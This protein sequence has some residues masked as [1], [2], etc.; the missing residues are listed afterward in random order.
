MNTKSILQHIR[1][2]MSSNGLSAYII[3]S[4]DRHQNEYVPKCWR[5]REFVSGF[6]GSAGDLLVGKDFSG[7]WTDSRYHLQAEQQLKGT[8]IVLFK[9]GLQDVPSMNEYIAQKLSAGDAVGL[10]PNLFSHNA[11]MKLTK[12]LGSKSIKIK[13]ILENPVDTFSN[14]N[15]DIPSNIITPHPD[16]FSGESIIS[17]LA[18]TREIMAKFGSDVLLVNT[19]DSVA[20]VY[21]IRGTDV[22]YNPVAIGYGAIETNTAYLFVAKEK[23]TQALIKH[24]QDTVVIRDYNEFEEYLEKLASTKKTIIA[25]PENVS[26]RTMELIRSNEPTNR[27]TSVLFARNPITDLKAIKNE[28]ELSGIR[29]AHKRDGVALV[30]FF[31]WLEET[32]PQQILTEISAAE[33]LADFRSQGKNYVGPSF[34]IISAFGPNGAVVH[35]EA[36]SQTDLPLVADGLYLLD[37]GAQYL[38]GTTDITRTIV[39]GTPTQEQRETFTRVLKGHINLI[40]TIFPTGTSGGR[41]DVLARKYLWEKCLN[42]GH[43]TGHGVGAYLCVHEGPHSISY[44]KG[45]DTPLKEGMVLSVEPGFYKEGEWGIRIENL[46][47][48][49]EHHNCSDFLC[50]EILS[51]C[52]IDLRLI[53]STLLNADEIDFINNYHLRV[54][55]TLKPF[56]NKAEQK[57]LKAATKKVK[58]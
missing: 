50:F 58:K 54:Y 39:I 30:R 52:P 4:S 26:L 38:D 19:L 33:K 7:L 49:A 43:G 37:S 10:D 36:S 23:V 1:N 16:I 29:N 40:S 5:R 25:D 14:H 24:L 6:T 51:L 15:E 8:E 47:A 32:I 56:L 11:G 46:V 31:K 44:N 2:F 35:Y 48:V 22:Q 53:D 12:D 3:P 20:W 57:W 34:G 42:Y 27:A 55:E 9:S 28:I 13:Y 17:K 41:L 21:N 45:K 18:K